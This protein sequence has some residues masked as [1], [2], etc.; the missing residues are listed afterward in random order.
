MGGGN[1]FGR[2]SGVRFWGG[3]VAKGQAGRPRRARARWERPYRLPSPPRKKKTLEC[4]QAKHFSHLSLDRPNGR[5]HG[6]DLGLMVTLMVT[7]RF[8]RL[9]KKER[10]SFTSWSLNRPRALSPN[11]AQLCVR[12]WVCR[13][14]LHPHRRLLSR[15]LARGRC[16]DARCNNEQRHTL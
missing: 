4:F 8:D 2:P 15:R 14:L 9:K 1:S 11:P 7:S 5:V 13:V 12:L 10:V 16:G 3:G 6:R